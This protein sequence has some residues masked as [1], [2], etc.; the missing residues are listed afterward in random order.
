MLELESSA[1][2]LLATFDNAIC[3]L[4]NIQ[5]K[6][7]WKEGSG[8]R[9][10]NTKAKLLTRT[11]AIALQFTTRE[12]PGCLRELTVGAPTFLVQMY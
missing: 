2:K 11:S 7:L 12:L 10:V 5:W 9:S 1:A 3:I 4:F 8:Q 6:D